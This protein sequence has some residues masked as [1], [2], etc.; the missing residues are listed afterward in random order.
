MKALRDQLKAKDA[1]LAAKKTEIDGWKQR[2]GTNNKEIALLRDALKATR[3]QAAK[4]GNA[5]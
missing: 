5:S 4:G 2:A 1:E 3:Q